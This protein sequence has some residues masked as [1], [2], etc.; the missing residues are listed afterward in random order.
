MKPAHLNRVMKLM[1]RT[2]DRVVVLDPES[3]NVVVMMDIDEYEH[4]TNWPDHSEAAIDHGVSSDPWDLPIHGGDDSFFDTPDASNSEAF[5]SDSSIH[6][7]GRTEN[8]VPD[9][10]VPTGFSVSPAPAL[11][12]GEEWDPGSVGTV[13]TEESLDDVPHSEEAYAEEASPSH[14]PKDGDEPVF[15][16]EPVE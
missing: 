12:F 6:P 16:L 10:P 14:E 7:P 3:D 1:R 15:H 8:W 4:L 13:L 5:F 9:Q 11:S 2:Q